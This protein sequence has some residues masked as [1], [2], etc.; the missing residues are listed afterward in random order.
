MLD[1]SWGETGV[2]VGLGLV[3][4]GRRDLPLASHT[5]GK[6]IGRIVGLLQGARLRADR[7]AHD[8][9]LKALQNE[10]RSGLRELDAVKAELAG[11]MMNNHR[12]VGAMVPG[13]D[14]RRNTFT[15]N[16][17]LGAASAGVASE[18][19]SSFSGVEGQS[20]KMAAPPPG[21]VDMGAEYLAAAQQAEAAH[22]NPPISGDFQ[23]DLAPKSRSIAAVAEEEWEKQGI[24]FRSVAEQG[25]QKGIDSNDPSSSNSV[26]GGATILSNFIRQSLI[27]DQY[28]RTVREQD[29]ALRSRVEKVRQERSD[30]IN[31]R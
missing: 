10:F 19:V 12:G 30:A 14:R 16:N 24:G 7:F 27:Y 22:S 11:A 9:Q 26:K 29:E 25:N 20:G 17:I 3:L 8:H 5:L 18:T 28:E 15:K 13:V 21:G 4:I 23:Y 31:K 2:L 6:Q 1:I